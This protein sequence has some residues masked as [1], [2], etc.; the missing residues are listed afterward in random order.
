[1]A[2]VQQFLNVKA[3]SKR[4]GGRGE[5]GRSLNPEE[6][7]RTLPKVSGFDRKSRADARLSFLALRADFN[8]SRKWDGG[9]PEFRKNAF[10]LAKHVLND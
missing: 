5:D 8:L 4:M 2:L 1:V 3:Q 6:S 7:I 10:L 9:Q